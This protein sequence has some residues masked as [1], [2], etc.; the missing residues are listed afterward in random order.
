MNKNNQ[1]YIVDK[2]KVLR[3]MDHLTRPPRL[4][5]RAKNILKTKKTGKK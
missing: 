3:Q 4:E 1:Q 5:N 2:K